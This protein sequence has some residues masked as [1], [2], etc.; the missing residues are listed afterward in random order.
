MGN[1]SAVSSCFWTLK[2]EAGFVRDTLG[3]KA[4]EEKLG[5]YLLQAGVL[6]PCGLCV[7]ILNEPQSF[8]VFLV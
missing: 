8:Q 6:G 2:Q 7:F 3:E 1:R 4:L 5:I